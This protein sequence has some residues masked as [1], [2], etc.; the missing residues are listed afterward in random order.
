MQHSGAVAAMFLLHG[1]RF[2]LAARELS[3]QTEAETR[4]E[5]PDLCAW[6]SSSPGLAFSLSFFQLDRSI[7]SHTSVYHL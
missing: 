5:G 3:M 2:V 7:P 6:V 4:D 1:G